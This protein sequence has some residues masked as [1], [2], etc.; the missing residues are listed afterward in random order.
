MNRRKMVPFLL[1]LAFCFNFCMA[2]ANGAAQEQNQITLE[3][4]FNQALTLSGPVSG[5][6]PSLV[7]ILR[8]PLDGGLAEYTFIL[9]VGKGRY[10]RIGLHRVVKE[11]YPFIPVKTDRVV[12]MVHGDTSD[13]HSTFLMTTDQDR[14]SAVYLAQK[15]IDVW[16]IDLRWALVPAATTDFSFMQGWN[17][18]THLQD[19]DLGMKLARLVRMLTG[20]GHDKIFLLGHSRGAQL[21]Y[22]YANQ[23]TQLSEKQRNLR[24]IIPIDMIYK[25]PVGEQA[26]KDAAYGRYLAYKSLYDSGQYHS[27]EGAQ[28]K[29]L[30]ALAAAAPHDPSPA[31]PGMTNMQAALLALTSTYATIPAPLQ[32][33]TPF[34]HYLAGAFDDNGLPAG[35]RYAD[36]EYVSRIALSSPD[37]QS[38]GEQ[39]DGEALISDAVDVPYDD[40]LGDVEVP[41]LYVGAA[42]GMGSYGEYTQ[43]LL[44][45]SDQTSLIIQKESPDLAVLDFGHADLIWA[46]SALS[47]VWQTIGQWIRTH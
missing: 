33:I 21:V 41:V 12:M 39:I 5:I 25:L 38:L 7:S 37:Y 23:E 47:E 11:K 43:T 28:L 10:D 46:D 24:G 17:S 18:D 31:V 40:H 35:L 1:C 44:G 13:F 42:G 9:K 27:D 29:A 36:Y 4:S 14:S 30:A 2:P 6:A 8:S 22:A 45:S 32:P 16:G 19:I 34:Y 26:L 20:S 15:D 3:Q